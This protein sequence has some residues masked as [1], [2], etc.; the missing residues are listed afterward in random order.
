VRDCFY[1]DLADA[2]GETV[3]RR[4][5]NEQLDFRADAETRAAGQK[6]AGPGE[7]RAGAD[8]KTSAAGSSKEIAASATIRFRDDLP[9]A[10][11]A[12]LADAPS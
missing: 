7:A 2:F 6:P 10:E 12:E 11:V 8:T 1:D 4:G 3:A 9:I 5:A